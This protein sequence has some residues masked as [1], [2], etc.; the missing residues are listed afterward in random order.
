M[1]TA[2]VQSVSVSQQAAL[3]SIEE[4]HGP[5]CS[6]KSKLCCLHPNPITP[7]PLSPLKSQGIRKPTSYLNNNR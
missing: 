1:Y 5:K 6:L 3:L 4:E 2:C 7:P